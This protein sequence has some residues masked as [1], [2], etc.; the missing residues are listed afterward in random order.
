MMKIRY[1][2]SVLASIVM[3][4]IIAISFATTTVANEAQYTENADTLKAL[5]LFIGTENGFELTKTSTRA[6]AAVM[7]VR[8]LGAEIQAVQDYV[9]TVHP[10]TDVPTWANPYINY[11][12]SKGLTKGISAKSYGSNNQ[13]T[14]NEYTTMILRALGYH[15]QD[16]LYKWDT[17]LEYSIT[18]GLLDQQ[19][20][21]TLM[22]SAKKALLRDEMVKI[23]YKSLFTS[24]MGE[25]KVLLQNLLDQYAISRNKLDNA[26]QIDE[27]LAK[28]NNIT[29]NDEMKGVWITYLELQ[30][31]F[32]ANKS[33][34]SFQQ[35]MNTYY[36]NLKG[37]GLNTVFIQVRPFSDAIY[38]SEYYPWS[39]IVTGTEG[40]A[41]DFDPFQIMVDEAHKQGLKIE[42]WIN[43]FR[44]RLPDSKVE[45]SA[46]NKALPWLSDGSNRVIQ[47]NEG[48]FYNP[49]SQDVRT[50]ITQGVIELV[51][52]YNIDGIHFDD[53]FYPSTD[54]TYDRVD[55]DQYKT[56]GGLLSQQD[57]RRENV[58]LL[59]RAVYS[60][61]KEH[62]PEV[63]FGISPQA[64]FVANYDQQFIDVEKWVANTGYIDYICP[65]VYFGY[66]HNKY[67][68]S[69]YI[70][71]WDK[72]I[73]NDSVKLYIGIAAYKIG[74][75][76]KWAGIGKLEWIESEK[77]LQTMIRD[78]RKKEHYEGFI[79]YRYDYLFEIGSDG[80]YVEQMDEEIEALKGILK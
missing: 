64:S 63:Q 6:E 49:A 24:M 4:C 55:F 10:F 26:R 9:K 12:Y 72:I 28:A 25:S 7:L 62:N 79:L 60:A 78:A 36:E 21:T 19:E 74:R 35:A 48:T 33:V 42:A 5:G 58:N 8:L 2:K 73:K 39:Y 52:K 75:E 11:L 53:Y 37:I 45:I 47:I 27:V 44:I 29:G 77:L 18:V 20:L 40:V 1:L 71:K 38:A 67:P 59:V 17:S 43:P 3:I 51:N 57:W 14:G 31:M 32:A 54:L 34:E 16:G 69:E 66:N 23:S 50:M 76:D 46:D 15:D 41:P 65:Q 61:I 56:A 80:T 30:K 22:P 68:Y 13:I 70:D